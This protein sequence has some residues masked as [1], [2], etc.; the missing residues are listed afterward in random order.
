MKYSLKYIELDSQG[1]PKQVKAF[2][3]D[4]VVYTANLLA[5]QG[6]K[7]RNDAKYKDR[8]YIIVDE[9]D[10]PIAA[11]QQTPGAVA[12]PKPKKGAKGLSLDEVK[13]RLRRC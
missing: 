13:R 5:L 2:A 8:R 10:E 3:N 11:I 1:K 9:N 7:E 12:A 6:L 4:E